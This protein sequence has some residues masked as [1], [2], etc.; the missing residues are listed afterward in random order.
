MSVEAD[1]QLRPIGLVDIGTHVGCTKTNVDSNGNIGTDGTLNDRLSS[2]QPAALPQR[3]GSRSIKGRS[4][5][6]DAQE[7]KEQGEELE[8]AEHDGVNECGGVLIIGGG[9]GRAVSVS[10][11]GFKCRRE[12]VLYT[13]LAHIDSRIPW[14]SNR[15][16]ARSLDDQN[17]TTNSSIR[18]P[19]A[20]HPG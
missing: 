19:G 6:A 12:R 20:D 2:F 11:N 5:G 8:E 16:P 9:G 13:S 3:S 4:E 18:T 1:C 10:S 15:P 14:H 7:R 17:N